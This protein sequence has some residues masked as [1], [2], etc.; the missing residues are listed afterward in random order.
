MALEITMKVY[1]IVSII[2]VNYNGKKY[3]KECFDSLYNLNYPSDRIEIIMVDNG[4]SDS[5]LEFTEKSYPRVKVIKNNINNYCK[6]INLGINSAKGKYAA[7]LNNDTKV[8]ENWLTELVKAIEADKQI[9]GAGSKILY[10]DGKI[11]SAG[12]QELPNFYWSDKD[13]DK[14]FDKPQDAD[15]LCGCAILYRKNALEDVGYF[16]EDFN[17]Y[18]E[19][20]DMSI[21]MLRTK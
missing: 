6:A 1:P 15:S 17:M 14:Q 19:D 4:S 8:D 5:S 7:M 18:L 11:E 13:H 21:R 2:I 12:H 20:V 3:L 16:D 10:M 9:G